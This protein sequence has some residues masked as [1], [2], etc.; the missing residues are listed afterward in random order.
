MTLPVAL[1]M[2]AVNTLPPV[3]L[4]VTAKLPNVPTDVMLVCAA[5]VRVPTMLVPLILPP[6][7]LP[8]ALIIPPVST[9]P[10]VIFATALNP[11]FDVK[12]FA[13]LL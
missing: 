12:V 11:T 3:A 5:V 6:V 10:L 8:V 13:E 1:T 4:P 2:P 9:F 7:I